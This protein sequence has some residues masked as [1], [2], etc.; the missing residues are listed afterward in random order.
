[1][2]LN[3]LGWAIRVELNQGSLPLMKPVRHLHCDE[4]YGAPEINDLHEIDYQEHLYSVIDF[5]RQ[6]I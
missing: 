5:T 4:Q 1:L 6:L 3:Y 2:A